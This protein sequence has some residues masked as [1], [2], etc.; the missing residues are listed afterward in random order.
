MEEEYEAI[1]SRGA[2]ER[3]H[4]VLPSYPNYRV[5]NGARPPA[6]PACWHR[7]SKAPPGLPGAHRRTRAASPHRRPLLF[8]A[9]CRTSTA[10][11]LLP[12]YSALVLLLYRSAHLQ[13]LTAD[14]HKPAARVPC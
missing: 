6:C 13:E 7:R 1:E 11:V 14:A 5:R 8:A 4:V 3:H 12:V 9:P 10:S 2:N